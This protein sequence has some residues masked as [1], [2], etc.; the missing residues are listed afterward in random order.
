ML[1]KKAGSTVACGQSASPWRV[2]NEKKREFEF[3]FGKGRKLFVKV[4]LF[5]FSLRFLGVYAH[6]CLQNIAVKIT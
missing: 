2:L 5:V 6:F 3:V 4:F 1:K